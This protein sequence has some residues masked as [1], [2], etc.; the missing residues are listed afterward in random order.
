MFARAR[1]DERLQRFFTATW[2][3]T[4]SASGVFPRTP[5]GPSGL[6]L[7]GGV[8]VAIQRGPPFD[9]NKIGGAV[10]HIFNPLM[11]SESSS[12]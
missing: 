12:L 5:G 11:T 2:H 3:R 9:R 1:L 7:R 10:E 6:S 8:E 4:L